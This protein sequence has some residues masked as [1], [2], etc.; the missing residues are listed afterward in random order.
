MTTAHAVYAPSSAPRWMACTASAE[1]VAALGERESG[2]AAVE[3]T[4]AHSE[5]ERVLGHMNGLMKPER[6]AMPVPDPE[7]E[8]AWGIALFLDY[9]RQLAPG[10]IW[11]E[12]RVKLTDKIWGRPDVGHW[13]EE[14]ATLTVP[15]YKNGFVDVDPVENEQL[16]IY[17]AGLIYTHK[18]P[19][20]WIRYAIVQPNSFM[21]VPRVK[22]WVE[23]AADLFEFAKRAA[24]VPDGPKTFV[25]GEHCRDCPLFGMCPPT[26][27]IVKNLGLMM[28]RPATDA[29]PAQ[30]AAFQAAWKPIEHWFEA[31]DKHGAKLALGGTAI[32]GMKLVTSR[33]NR[34]WKD[35]SAA[36]KFVMAAK[37]VDALDPPTPAQAEKLGL[38]VTALADT[39]PGR[40][41]LAFESDSRKPWVQK[42]GA[43]MFATALAGAK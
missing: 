1:A 39:P 5:I 30:I 37:G 17:A 3:G 9:V 43:E 28:M 26:K 21:P 20:K 8:A 27:D 32:P 15:D 35:V 29:T 38:D 11:V 10:R 4:Q 12:Q 23:P 24:A 13:H 6:F 31:L 14:T 36:R 41:V 40:P 19:A 33:G 25:A 7:H 18:L 2:E 34:A 16:R 22:Q 42:T